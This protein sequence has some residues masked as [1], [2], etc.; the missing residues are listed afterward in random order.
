[1]NF[2]CR[3]DTQGKPF[4]FALIRNDYS[5]ADLRFCLNSQAVLLLGDVTLPVHLSSADVQFAAPVAS[6]DD[7]GDPIITVEF[8]G[9]CSL[10]V[11]SQLSQ[12]PADAELDVDLLI[13]LVSGDMLEEDVDWEF[14]ESDT[15][16]LS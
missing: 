11:G 8:R 4:C 5:Y 3:F 9:S 12:L 7:L 1:M 15:L 13:S 2:N 10:D 6:I 14:V 16:R